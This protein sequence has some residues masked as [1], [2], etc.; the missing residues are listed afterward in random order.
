MKFFSK[1]FVPLDSRIT[2]II[3]KG[4]NKILN[5]PEKVFC[6]S[7]PVLLLL[8]VTPAIRCPETVRVIHGMVFFIS[9]ELPISSYNVRSPAK[10]QDLDLKCEI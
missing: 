5:K 9:R 2:T 3:R 8:E 10:T 1:C 4:L 7:T 6:V